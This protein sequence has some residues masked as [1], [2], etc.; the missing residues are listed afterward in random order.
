MKI[1]FYITKS[2]SYILLVPV[3]IIAIPGAI[4]YFLSETIEENYI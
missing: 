1:L 3:T 4:F 2:M